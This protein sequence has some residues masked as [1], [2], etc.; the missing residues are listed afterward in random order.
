MVIRFVDPLL[1]LV[2]KMK[3]KILEILE[4]EREQVCVI[5][6]WEDEIGW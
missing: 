5:K 4:N 3:M 1:L 6:G 2:M